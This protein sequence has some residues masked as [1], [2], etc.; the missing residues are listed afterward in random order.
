[1]FDMKKKNE[2]IIQKQLN[3]DYRNTLREKE[4]K[5]EI[6]FLYCMTLTIV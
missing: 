1:M 6:Q 3:K 2:G 4:R 5:Q